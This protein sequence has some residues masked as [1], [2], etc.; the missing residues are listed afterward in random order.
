[1]AKI[2]DIYG[3]NF[4]KADDIKGKGDIRVQIEHVTI[5]EYDGKKRAVL[6]FKGRDKVLPLNVT[7]ANMIA[8]IFATDEMDEWEGK[9]I[10]L[11]TTRVD[12]Q[13]KRVDAIR[14]KEANVSPAKEAFMKEVKAATRPA[15]KPEPEEYD[16]EEE[17]TSDPDSDIPF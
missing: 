5:D 9:R 4:L 15:P 17:F 11:Y 16:K 13:G 10:T 1:M 8:E 14:I 7:N 12:F 3:G 6:H 2:G